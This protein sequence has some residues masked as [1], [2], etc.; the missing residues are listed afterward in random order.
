M[1]K[2]L[3]YHHHVQLIWK[4]T[5]VLSSDDTWWTHVFLCVYSLKIYVEVTITK[6]R[7][8]KEKSKHSAIP[9]NINILSDEDKQ[10]HHDAFLVMF[11]FQIFM[12]KIFQQTR[13]SFHHCQVYNSQSIWQCKN[14]FYFTQDF[15]VL[16]KK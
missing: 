6:R 10:Y 4:Y 14:Y 16:N 3:T 11:I 15:V 5:L 2:V 1:K 12:C 13:I 7:R 8:I 9:K